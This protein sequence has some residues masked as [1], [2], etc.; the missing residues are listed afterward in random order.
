MICVLTQ[1]SRIFPFNTQWSQPDDASC[2]ASDGHEMWCNIV[3]QVSLKCTGTYKTVGRVFAWHSRLD[4]QH[5]WE[6]QRQVDHYQYHGFDGEQRIN[7][8]KLFIAF[9]FITAYLLL[10]M[11]HNVEHLWIHL[12]LAIK[13]QVVFLALYSLAQQTKQHESVTN[14]FFLCLW[15]DFSLS[16]DLCFLWLFNGLS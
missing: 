9:S 4:T 8:V 13:L 5:L 11:L 15:L 2:W 3:V 7:K 14:T 16:L 12:Y 6:V 10:C 1:C